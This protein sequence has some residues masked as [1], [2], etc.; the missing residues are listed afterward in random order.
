M[1]DFDQ[2]ER[3]TRQDLWGRVFLLLIVKVCWVEYGT[4]TP[5][6]FIIS[7]L[8]KKGKNQISRHNFEGSILSATQERMFDNFHNHF[9]SF[10]MPNWTIL[11]NHPTMELNFGCCW[12]GQRKPSMIRVMR[13]QKDTPLNSTNLLGYNGC[14][15]SIDNQWYSMIELDMFQWSLHIPHPKN[16]RIQD[17]WISSNYLK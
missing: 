13:E 17:I 16:W 4:G 14:K 12:P 3:S 5:V 8:N 6:S 1:R 15:L 7:K 9:K 10:T 2:Y 11:S